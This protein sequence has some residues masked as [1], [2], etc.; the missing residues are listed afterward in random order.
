MSVR[1]DSA[2]CARWLVA[3]PLVTGLLLAPPSARSQ[4]SPAR[5]DTGAEDG[6]PHQEIT[7]AQAVARALEVDP[8]TV[9]AETAA[10]LARADRLETRGRWLPTVTASTAY[11]NSS[12]ERVD[13]S[14]GRLVSESYT[15]QLTSSLLIFEGGRRILENAEAGAFLVQAEAEVQAERYQTIL[16]T[17]ET[18]YA[19]AAAAAVVDL[20]TQ[21]RERA[22]QQL[23]FAR[24]RLEVGTATASDV[25]RAELE[26]GNA[27]LAVLDARSALRTTALQL[28]RLIG[29]AQEVHTTSTALP[30][31]APLLADAA[32]MT[33]YAAARSPL[34][35][36]A[37]AALRGERAAQRATYTHYL[38]TVRLSAGYDWLAFDFPPDRRSW[39]L[40]LSAS[41]P[42]FDGFVR[43]ARGRRAQAQ[44]RLADARAR[45]TVLAVRA[46]VAAAVQEIRAAEERVEI[47]D[48]GSRLAREDLRVLE[49]RYQTG[50]ATILEL[51]TSQVALTESE[52]GAIR[53]RQGLG[54]A[55]A[56]LEAV[57]GEPIEGVTSGSI[58]D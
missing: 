47:S 22:R 26:Q 9:A 46:E 51:Q 3:V 15:A 17:T 20:A 52:V 24:T 53:A 28:G 34:V 27:E 2:Q 5:S 29:V 25:L 43:E 49:E 41:L 58:Q 16:T 11:A 45:D 14:T 33:R 37:E 8:R 32:E 40:R 57:L 12:D 38:P 39:S 31:K 50:S 42:V 23:D 48:R 19:A 7:L 36:A 44:L 18:F 10:D 4:S 55:V 30:E 35:I 21:R 54:T 56:R 6:V 13:S 1:F